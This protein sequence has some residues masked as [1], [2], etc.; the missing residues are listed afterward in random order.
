MR[1]QTSPSRLMMPLSFAGLVSGME[2]EI[3][4]QAKKR[5][6]TF[7][8]ELTKTEAELNTITADELPLEQIEQKLLQT[9]Q[10]LDST[11]AI[12]DRLDESNRECISQKTTITDTQKRI[13]SLLEMQNNLVS[14]QK[15]LFALND[16]LNGSNAKHIQ[17]QS[18]ALGT[19][20]NDVVSAA[21][22]HFMLFCLSASL[23]RSAF[24]AAGS[25]PYFPTSKS[26]N[27]W[28][29]FA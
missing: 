16:D 21:N 9:Q 27:S 5:A 26:R 4:S 29:S 3:I 22:N 19:F 23:T 12:L 25:F 11:N 18:W 24:G 28:V 14:N 15:A 7:R 10:S 1:M 2:A 13:Q 6:A 20:L 17:F 8:T